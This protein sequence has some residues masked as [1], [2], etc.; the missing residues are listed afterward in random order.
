MESLRFAIR[1]AAAICL[2]I[3]MSSASCDLFQ[4][5]DVVTFSA[6][7]DHSF[8]ISEEANNP[9]GKDYTTNPVDEVLDAGDVN[10]D[11][12]KNADK[13]ESI[14]INSVTY[15]LSGYESQDCAK[16]AFTNGTLTFSDPDATNG[17][18]VVIS[19]ISHADLK[20]AQ[21]TTHT[22]TFTQAQAD[23]LANLLK[24]KKKV[25]IHAAGRLSCTELFLDVKATLDCKISA[26]VL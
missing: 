7:L 10:A 24:N 1:S 21:G 19:G 12:K 25:R 18:G 26:K 2:A 5:A 15:V 11:F 17:G 20:S 23:E 16:V 9:G 3:F 22:L 14:T 8:S 4:N 13:I 6:K